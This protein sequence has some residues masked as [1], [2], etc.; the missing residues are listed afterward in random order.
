MQW[1]ERRSGTVRLTLVAHRDWT[2]AS[3][4]GTEGPRHWRGKG[5]G[6]WHSKEGFRESTTAFLALE[7]E[8]KLTTQGWRSVSEVQVSRQSFRPQWRPA[9]PLT[10]LWESPPKGDNSPQGEE[11]PVW[12]PKWG[13]SPCSNDTSQSASRAAVTTPCGVP[14]LRGHG[15][16]KEKPAGLP[17][18]A[19]QTTQ[20]EPLWVSPVPG[21]RF[22]LWK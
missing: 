21:G 12:S 19:R 11:K 10:G 2:Q 8:P 16:Q 17:T 22:S 18:D 20:S 13:G 9:R 14:T 6:T 4:W 5:E 15:G 7:E 3:P 1:C